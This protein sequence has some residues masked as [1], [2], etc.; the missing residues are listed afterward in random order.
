MEAVSIPRAAELRT[1]RRGLGGKPY[2]GPKVQVHIPEM[3]YDAVIDEM[4][5]RGWS[6][7]RYPEMLREVFAAGVAA[8]G[9]PRGGA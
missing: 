4:E 2:I 5:A 1:P 8:L 6:E 3:D 9:L 7:D